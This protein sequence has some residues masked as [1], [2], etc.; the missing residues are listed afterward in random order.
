MLEADAHQF[1]P[2]YIFITE[3]GE[4]SSCTYEPDNRPV[5]S[6]N[7]PPVNNKHMWIDAL[8]EKLIAEGF[9]GALLFLCEKTAV[10]FRVLNKHK[11]IRQ[12]LLLYKIATGFPMAVKR[13]QKRN[14]DGGRIVQVCECLSYTKRAKR[15]VSSF[16]ESTEFT[17][18]STMA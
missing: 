4:L 7:L 13:V 9:Q 12:T 1:Y 10:G 2:C 15:K 16:M 3:N 8:C 18:V 5:Y 17:F 14:R 11:I 6:V